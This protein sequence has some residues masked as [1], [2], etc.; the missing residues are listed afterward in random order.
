MKKI[1]FIFHIVFVAGLFYAQTPTASQNY[2]YSKTYLSEDG[3]KKS[4][5]VQ[6]FDGLGRLKQTVSVK[7]TPSGKDL[8]VPVFYDELGRQPKDFLPLPITTAN[9]GIQPVSEADINSYYGVANAFSEKVFDNSPLGK[10]LEVAAP[11]D[12]WKKG[13]G[14]TIQSQYETNVSAD[15]VKKYV[16][17]SSWADATLSPSVPTVEWYAESQLMKNI[18][19]DEDGNKSIAFKNSQGQTVLARK[20][21]GSTPVDTYYI[22]NVYDQLAYV[23]TPKADVQISQ[24]GNVVTQTVLNDF[25]YQ[26]KYDNKN[27]L[28]EKY[29]PGKGW[30]HMVYDK[31]NR[32]IF[33][34]DAVMRS[35]GKWLF[36]KY[37]QFGRVIYTGFILAAPRA[38]LQD[39]AD[40]YVVIDSR[41]ATGFTKN[42]MQVYYT[43]ILFNE[44]ITLLSVNYY[45]D[46][47]SGAPARPSTILGKTT[48]SATPTQY[49][50]NGI[51][52][53]RSI[54]GMPTSS[55]VKNIEDDNWSQSH[56]WYDTDGR[57]IGTHSINHLGGYTKTETDLDFAGAVLQT[58]TYHKRLSTDTEKIITETFEYDSQ[59]RLL[60]HKHQID[61][62]PVEVLS[63]NVYNDLGQ[64]EVKKVGNTIASPLQTVNYTYNI[65][66]KLTKI[67]DPDNL[68]S[69]L[70]GYKINYNQ[71]EGMETPNSDFTDLKVKAR[72]NGNIAEVSW[73][74]LTQENEPLKR[75]GYVYDNLDRLSAGFYQKAGSE[76]A[77]EFFEKIDYDIDGSISRLKRSEGVS[78]GNTFATMIDNLKYEYNGNK[79]TK[80][81]DEQQ[82]PSGYPYI[83]TPNTITYDT[84]GNMMTHLDKGISSIQYN[85]LN[86]PSQ[87]TQNSK[88]TNYTY[89]ADGVKVKKLFGDLETDYL[90]GFQYKST[91]LIESWNGQGTFHPDPNEVPELKLRIIPTSE[92][93]Y[94]AL[95]NQYVYNFTDHLGNVRLSYTDIS[96]D[97]VIQP[98][99][100]EFIQCSG[101]F[102]CTTVWQ[103]GEIVENNDYYPFGMLHNYT[104]TTQNSYQYK[105]NGKE[106]QETGMYDYGWRQYMPD[107]GRWTQIDPLSEKGHN[108]SPYNYAINNPILFIDPDGL[109]ISITDGENQY[110]Y[111][112]GHIQHEVGGEWVTIDG[113]DKEKLSTNVRKIMEGLIKLEAG[114][115]VG[116][117]MISFFDNSKNNINIQI[118]TGI[119]NYLN[120]V[121]YINPDLSSSYPTSDGKF[122]D[123][124]FFIKLG[125]EMAHGMDPEKNIDALGLWV[126]GKTKTKDDDVSWSEVYASHIENQLRGE[127]SLPL[128]IS[129]RTFIQNGIKKI[130][131]E[132]VLIDTVGNSVFYNSKGKR[133]DAITLGE[134][135]DAYHSFYNIFVTNCLT[136]RFNYYQNVKKK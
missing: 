47:P 13:S 82:N 92:G 3:S 90:D 5:A 38:S 93:Y 116:K 52:S 107:L 77:K 89:R 61:S 95:L 131:G 106:L 12:A 123:S 94:D 103:P 9:S 85:Y 68:G 114:G 74:T 24:N 87:I 35:S 75:Y 88:V 29:I 62:N 81:T 96:K 10:V 83:T 18:T 133:L 130:D 40:D 118:T 129:Y 48:L 126:G 121:A 19:I 8:V 36:T 70:F 45:D 22:Y 15:Q 4:E 127:N 73:K 113:K 86:L 25:C 111:T 57:A 1:L 102:L 27:R 132:T 65:H 53:Y 44:I 31:A 119:N 67:N 41:D 42:G 34:Q 7:S 37:D 134:K 97:G 98:R 99:Q 6:Y 30:E 46:Y 60:T 20:M 16:I 64:L 136:N 135:F 91:F 124:P 105:Y 50:S 117:G 55:Y 122:S 43:N 109:W 2:I 33:T 76:S 58:K 104:A 39:V 80:V 66:G 63:Q 51:V 108:F 54:K 28:V 112:S 59:N 32:L 49:S 115:D 72:Y 71:V 21:D 69:D 125:H 78:A 110:R 11:G 79:L 84:N 128:R 26:Y 14:H 17:T 23:I 100:Y 56:I 101:K 120:G